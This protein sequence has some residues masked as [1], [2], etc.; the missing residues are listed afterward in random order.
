[1]FRVRNLAAPRSDVNPLISQRTLAEALGTS[2]LA[3][4]SVLAP[5][6]RFPSKMRRLELGN[7]VGLR[8]L[9]LPIFPGPS[10]IRN[11]VF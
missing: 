2:A 5:S 10:R 9:C 11:K 4:K 7:L 6:Q 8:N 3:R 1:M